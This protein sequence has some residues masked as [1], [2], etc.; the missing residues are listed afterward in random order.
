[1][2]ITTAVRLVSAYS[3]ACCVME[4]AAS[5][6][7]VKVAAPRPAAMAAWSTSWGR[8]PLLGASPVTSTT[9]ICAW[10]ASARAVSALV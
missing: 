8:A 3:T 7:T 2:A 10:T 5:R 9:G 1:M 6:V 4:P